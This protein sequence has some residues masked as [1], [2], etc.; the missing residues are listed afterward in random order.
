LARPLLAG[1]W[2]FF[3]RNDVG[4]TSPRAKRISGAEK[5]RLRAKKDFFNT[6]GT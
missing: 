4:F 1:L 2:S 3:V 6:I 5:N